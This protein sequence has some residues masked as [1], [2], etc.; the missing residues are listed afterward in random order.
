VKKQAL[1]IAIGIMLQVT[2]SGSAQDL[3]A[4]LDQYVQ[5]TPTS[6]PSLG[7]LGFSLQVP[8][9]DWPELGRY[10][11]P[12]VA[13]FRGGDPARTTLGKVTSG[14]N[15]PDS[16]TV[17]KNN[18]AGRAV[19]YS[20]PQSKTMELLVSRLSPAIMLR[21]SGG[22]LDLL[23]VAETAP[24][25]DADAK[26]ANV[27]YLAVPT[28]GA[29]RVLQGPIAID[30]AELSEPWLVVWFGQSSPAR[31]QDEDCPLLL[32]FQHRPEKVQLQANRGVSLRFAG[33][34]G[35]VPAP[36]SQN[37]DLFQVKALVLNEPA[38]KL[39]PYLQCPIALG[40]LYYLQNL[41]ATIRAASGVQWKSVGP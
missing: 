9:K 19:R 21:S 20:L 11:T 2:G 14:T 24:E 26:N 5:G 13:N 17:V 34:S 1:I 28:A 7:G 32:V 37:Y 40:D 23:N 27:R 39:E 22:I 25:K 30:G 38:E 4:G 33:D 36:Y 8:S 29:I 35:Y 15:P 41:T 6:S 10:L 3:Q 18:W 31:A 12:F 16:V